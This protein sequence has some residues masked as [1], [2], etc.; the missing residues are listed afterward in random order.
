MDRCNYALASYLA[1]RGDE[2]HLAAYRA[3]E[4]LVRRPNVLL[5]RVAKPLN[6]YM[7]GDPLLKQVG[8]RWAARIARQGGRILVNGG[9]CPW[10]D[11]NLVHHVNAVDPPSG[12]GSTLRRLKN[13][14]YHRR[15]V[16]GE[17]TTIPRARTIIADCERPARYFG[18]HPRGA[19]REFAR[20]SPGHRPGHLLSGRC[21]RA[22]QDPGATRM[23][24]R[25]TGS[26]VYRG[27][28]QSPEGV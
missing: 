24:G 16:A 19:A 12:G 13:R 1:R 17:R 9:N 7:L 20:R 28:G 4:D 18:T 5:H 10:Y 15:C 14:V 26:C 6:S 22:G 3:A 8:R 11:V 27:P 21:G 25:S 23:G 2:V